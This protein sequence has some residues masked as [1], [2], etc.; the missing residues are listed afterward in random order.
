MH[1]K[2]VQYGVPWWGDW[3]EWVHSPFTLAV[4]AQI[5]NYVTAERTFGIVY[6]NC[7]WEVEV[8]WQSWLEDGCSLHTACLLDGQT[9]VGKTK[10]W[11]DFDQTSCWTFYIWKCWVNLFV[12][13]LCLRFCTNLALAGRDGAKILRHFFAI[14]STNRNSKYHRSCKKGFSPEISS[15]VLQSQ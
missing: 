2:K 15:P 10:K 8:H 14:C 11:P 6:P 7:R 3:H 12:R 5:Q 1:F 9:N 4:G 13:F